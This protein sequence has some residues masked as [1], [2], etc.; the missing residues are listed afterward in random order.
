M[1][2]SVLTYIT[3]ALR[4]IGQ[5]WL[6]GSGP[7]PEAQGEV[8]MFLNQMLDSWNTMRNMVYTILDQTFNLLNSQYIYTMGPNG[9]FN[10]PRPVK[11]QKMDL[12]YQTS[13]E[14]FRLPI[15]VIDVDQ[16][17][18]ERVPNLPNAIPLRCYCD[19]GYSQAPA[20]PGL[21]TL[22]FWPGPMTAQ[23][24]EIWSWGQLNNALTTASTLYVPPGYQRGI[25]YN[26]A[27]DIMPLY[28]KRLTLQR[29]QEILRIAKEARDSI[30]AVNAPVP[31]VAIDPAVVGPVASGFNWLV[32][33]N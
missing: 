13:P 30:N 4:L 27:A 1:N 22:Y 9:N 24:V 25:I 5:L 32:S 29:E 11:I 21:A 17:S 8:C 7:S 33:T 18:M 15:D 20:N 31:I 2:T 23:E 19:Y 14:I 12:I 3:A 16:W 28:P 26:L 6:P 10:G